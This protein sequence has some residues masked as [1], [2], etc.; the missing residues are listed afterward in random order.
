M[1][2]PSRALKAS[3][4]RRIAMETAISRRTS[5]M[6]TEPERP[7]WISSV[8]SDRKRGAMTV[9]TEPAAARRTARRMRE[10]TGRAKARSLRTVGTIAPTVRRLTAPPPPPG[11]LRPRWTLPAEASPSSRLETEAASPRSTDSRSRRRASCAPPSPPAPP[12]AS[13]ARTP[14]S[15]PLMPAPLRSTATGRSPCTRNTSRG[16]RNGFPLRRSSPGRP[17]GCGRPRARS[18]SSGRR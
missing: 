17:R 9:I 3:E 2:T 12:A 11:S 5:A 1:I 8:M 10:R 14:L 16:A 18:R 15:C 4:P 7:A 13:R 6:S